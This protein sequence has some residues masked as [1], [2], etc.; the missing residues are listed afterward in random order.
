MAETI[1]V[2]VKSQARRKE[3]IQRGQIGT[4]YPVL[5]GPTD[6]T[7]EFSIDVDSHCLMIL[8]LICLLRDG[9]VGHQFQARL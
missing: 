7:Y 6:G 5:R 1:A 3:G 2:T 8:S 4:T 9:R